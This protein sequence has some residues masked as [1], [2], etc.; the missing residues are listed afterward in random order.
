[1][2]NA[3]KFSNEKSIVRVRFDRKDDRV[4]VTVSDSGRGIKK[5]DPPKLLQDSKHFTTFDTN[6][7]EGSGLGLLLCRDFVRKNE[8][9]LWFE[10]EENAGSRFR[11]PLPELG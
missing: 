4:I 7:E 9:E 3:I 8:G 10:S 11:F 6:S 2:S 1:M 5:E